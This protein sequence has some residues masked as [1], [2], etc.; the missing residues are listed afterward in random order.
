MKYL[1]FKQKSLTCFV[2]KFLESI[3]DKYNK[4]SGIITRTTTV[5]ANVV[6][7]PFYVLK[8]SCDKNYFDPICKKTKAD[9]YDLVQKCDNSPQ[10]TAK[11]AQTCNEIVSIYCYVFSK[12]DRITCMLTK[13]DQYVPGKKTTTLAPITSVTPTRASTTTRTIP[14][15]TTTSTTTTTTTTTRTTTAKL[16]TT[17]SSSTY[18]FNMIP[19]FSGTITEV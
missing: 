16:I 14:T 1:F 8:N 19:G 3:F 4:Y 13:H 9:L 6:D 10:S 18:P 12:Y 2:W 15:T 11:M 17:T 5:A 7:D